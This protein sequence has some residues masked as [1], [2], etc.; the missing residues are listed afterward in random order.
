MLPIEQR[1]PVIK[2]F[3]SLFGEP[4]FT[5]QDDYKKVDKN[6]TYQVK[7][8]HWRK[9]SMQL[10]W[11]EECKNSVNFTPN[12]NR[13]YLF[14]DGSIASGV[15]NQS[16]KK[17][18]SPK[19][20]CFCIDIDDACQNK[21]E[22]FAKLYAKIMKAMQTFIQPSLIVQTANGFHI[23]W[24]IDPK[25]RPY[26]DTIM[27]QKDFEAI[28]KM[29]CD[30]FLADVS[31]AWIISRFRMPRTWHHKTEE[32][33]EVK[34]IIPQWNFEYE[35][36]MF[37]EDFDPEKLRYL[38]T[39]D[40]EMLKGEYL[41]YVKDI[42]PIQED[43]RKNK[44]IQESQVSAIP[45]VDIFKKLEWYKKNGQNFFLQSDSWQTTIPIHIRNEN[46][47]VTE[48][49][50]YRLNVEKNYVNN[51]TYM[52]HEINERP[53][54][55]VYPFLWHYFGKDHTKVYKFLKNEYNI[56]C[57]VADK[58]QWEIDLWEIETEECRFKGTNKWVLMFHNVVGAKQKKSVRTS[59][60]RNPFTIEWFI[61]TNI[62]E[63]W[64]EWDD[65]EVVYL[66][67]MVNT[68]ELCEVR[69]YP[70]KNAFNKKYMSKW[71]Y[72]YWFDDSL[73]MFFDALSKLDTVREYNLVVWSGNYNWYTVLWPNVL[74]QLPESTYLIPKET[75]DL[76]PADV[77]H[78]SIETYFKLME[79]RYSTA[80]LH[81]ALLQWIVLAGMNV[82]EQVGAGKIY[83]SLLLTGQTGTGKSQL[84]ERIKCMIGMDYSARILS[85]SK[86]SPQP[87][88]QAATDYAPLFLQELTEDIRPEVESLVRNILNHE[89]AWRGTV[90]G[91]LYYRLRS[92]LLITGERITNAESINNRLIIIQMKKEHLL[93]KDAQMSEFEKTRMFSPYK[94][95]YQVYNTKYMLI[96]GLYTKYRTY[97]WETMHVPKR[98]VELLTPMFVVNELFG[99]NIPLESIISSMKAILSELGINNKAVITEQNPVLHLRN[100]LL[101]NVMRH[102]VH[103]VKEETKNETD[104]YSFV[105]LGDEFQKIKMELCTI[106]DTINAQGTW[107]QRMLIGADMV[108]IIIHKDNTVN[109]CDID[110]QL[111]GSMK[112]LVGNGKSYGNKF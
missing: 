12:G 85:I 40:L 4:A 33:I 30:Y 103:Y 31:K 19:Y 78:C 14:D 55:S 46:G 109:C 7:P 20:N 36:T 64:A 59:V 83:P 105:F 41:S 93:G 8:F 22:N 35:T 9:L 48:T 63:S 106:A 23:Y 99:I 86:I 5:W 43:F 87:L 72:F 76:V 100:R 21:P 32:N 24:I 29:F 1:L 27:E 92:P 107:W 15:N 112:H 90:D 71:L 34:V 70:Q 69:Q 80:V 38:S 53:R 94:E 108:Q 98:T 68:G 95:I 28:Q 88:K 75:F 101:Q 26:A 67:K 73:W 52:N 37:A 111:R 57:F 74:G 54:G 110:D 3:L 97:L 62:K 81:P 65:K 56:N 18:K 50:W 102:K 39:K 77:S 84:E 82:R 16:V 66:F 17:L 44:S 13:G 2:K 45:F 61:T 60:F 51:F 25:R 58:E 6:R 47:S 11:N 91:N 104:S 89:T 10:K 49:D 42:A 96:P 79:P